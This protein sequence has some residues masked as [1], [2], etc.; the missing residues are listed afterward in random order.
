MKRIACLILTAG[1]SGIALADEPAVE[2]ASDV[3]PMNYA[4]HLYINLTTGERV[5]FPVTD[6]SAMIWANSSTPFSMYYSVDGRTHSA[7]RATYGSMVESCGDIAF[8]ASVD[9]IDIGYAIMGGIADPL[10]AGITGLSIQYWFYDNDNR[11]N[12]AGAT[13]VGAVQVDDIPGDINL[14]DFNATGYTATIDGITPFILGDLTAGTGHDLDGDGLA[15]IGIGV[16]MV[17]N[18]TP[19]GVCGPLLSLPGNAGG[20]QLPHSTGV[21]DEIDWYNSVDETTGAKLSF[22]GR[23]SFG[24]YNPNSNPVVP[25]CSVYVG[26]RG[27][28]PA[29]FCPADFNQDGVVDFFDYDDFILC[30]EGTVCP[31]G[32]TADFNGDTAIDFFDYDDFIAAFSLPCN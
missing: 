1:I 19:K 10:S 14:F 5:F 21:L 3:R 27:T 22:K 15:D 31:P 16:R 2:S 26:L 24:G 32:T 20:T 13:Y 4:G 8:G 12:S 30:F 7:G 25:Y 17:Q 11:N 29:T 6:R 28:I 9:S 23:W 18:T